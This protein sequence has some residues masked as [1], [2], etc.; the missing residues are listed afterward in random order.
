MM[1]NLKAVARALGGVVYGDRIAAPAP[2]HSA[3]DR[4]MTVWLDPSDPDG[5]KV[6]CFTTDDWR[7]CRDYVRERLGL[8]R[9]RR[10]PEIDPR[11]ARNV[12][13]TPATSASAERLWREACSPVRSPTERYLA[14]RGLAL[15]PDV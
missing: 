8:A 7:G 14:S 6:S 10:Q 11:S 1:L 15:T 2:G 5:F 12:G 9:R 3:K 13:T 4:S